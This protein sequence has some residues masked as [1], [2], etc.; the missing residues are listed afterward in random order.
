MWLAN[1]ERPLNDYTVTPAVFMI[2]VKQLLKPV[3]E[4]KPCGKNLSYDPTF[5]ALEGLIVGKPETQF[6]A[7]EEPDWKAVRDACPALLGQSKDLRVAVILCLALV[8]LEGAVGL[9]DGLALLKGSLERYWPDLYPNASE[10]VKSQY[11]LAAAEV[12]VEEVAG[13]PGYY[14]SKFF[15]RPHYQPEGLTASL[16]LVTKLPSVKA[17]AS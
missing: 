2:E 9:R 8:K 15:L 13:N 6:S 17:G 4:E 12:T 3:S 16:R 7:A 5:L 10:A 11:P 1:A 14:T